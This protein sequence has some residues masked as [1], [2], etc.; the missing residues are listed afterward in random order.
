MKKLF[1]VFCLLLA[2]KCSL[3]QRGALDFDGVDDY[4]LITGTAKLNGPSKITLE[5]W[6]YVTD[7]N[8]SPCAD[9]AP[10]IWN[11]QKSY[12]FGTGNTQQV[13]V[14]LL[15]GTSAATL[16]SAGTISAKKWH[17]IAATF[18]GTKLKLY[19]D[20]KVTDSASYSS[21]AITYGSSTSDVW[22]ADPQTGFGGILEET[23]IWDYERSAAEIKEGTYKKY[24]SSKSGLVLQ[25][26]YEDGTPY[27]NNTSVTSIADNTGNKIN[28][29][30]T[31]FKMKDSTSNFVLGRSY[32]DT[33]VYSKYSVSSCVKYLLPSKKRIVTVS[34]DYQDTIVSY[35]GC[36]SVMT[37][38]VNILKATAASVYISGCDSVRNPITKKFYKFSGK[39]T[40]TIFNSVGCDSVISFFVTIYKKSK[41]NLSYDA[42]NFVKLGNGKTVTNSGVYVDT[43]KNYRGC[44][45]LIEH[46]VNIRKSS[47][48]KVSLKI[49][50]FVICPTNP[51]LIFNKPGVYYDTIT[52][53][54]SCD[55]IIEYTVL[56]S[57]TYGII[58]AI[59]CSGY[60]SPSKKYNWTVSG[61]YYD[62][63]FGLNQNN[64]DSFITINLTLLSPSKQTLNISECRSYKVPSGT[65]IVTSSSVVNDVIKSKNGCDSIQYTI[66]VN[67]TR[68]NTN[69]TRTG[70]TLTA[71]SSVS[72]VNYRWLDC[73]NNYATIAGE[74]NKSFT[75]SKAGLYALAVTENTCID[76]SNCFNFSLAGIKELNWNDVSISPIPSKGNFVIQSNLTLHQ[77]KITLVNSIGEPLKVWNA[78]KLKN[79]NFE[80]NVPA[81]LYLI[82]IES[83]EGYMIKYIL[84][85]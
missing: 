76:T 77:V 46:T 49:C 28:G 79:E 21:F 37:I 63:L 6:L 69:Y 84:F 68:A 71:V 47:F 80:V 55:S 26:S 23:R 74:T 11:Q 59:S 56:S 83:N 12:R 75:P 66:N 29:V 16:T 9:C 36:D 67:I 70:N 31:N 33:A 62:T 41:T 22:I 4:I 53:K 7:F 2:A 42:C 14:S 60:K 81:A 48:A 24:P 50:V 44:D 1:T 10:I 58:N 27:G 78:D 82:R 30:P 54:V 38:K 32:C 65:K 52:N 34:G 8:T 20:G 18:N 64:C 72:G 85:E 25:Y 51:T 3:A 15:N 40:T 43:L 73:N 57:S 5:T 61:T 19:I 13:F 39:Y 17:H 45:S 35:R